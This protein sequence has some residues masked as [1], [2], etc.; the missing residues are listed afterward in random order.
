[1][2]GPIRVLL[3][4]DCR[5][6]ADVLKVVLLCRERVVLVGVAHDLAQASAFLAARAADLVL[7]HAGG[8]AGS[9]AD[10]VRAL[11]ARH[12]ESEVVALGLEESEEAILQVIEAGA[13][14]YALKSASL[15]EVLATVE[16]VH[17]GRTVCSPRVMGAVFDR[18]RRL[19]WDRPTPP[20]GRPERLSAREE[21]VLGMLAAGLSNKEIAHRLG[22][23]LCT[24]KNHVHNILDKLHVRDRRAAVRSTFPGHRPA[25]PGSIP[26]STKRFFGY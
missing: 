26:P 8:G 4:D 21:E 16:S 25:P 17:E 23:T 6:L 15:E 12:P 5:L 3:V 10:R 18:V 2:A 22:I 13:G 9:A 1:M 14:G 7:V 20:A 11:K 19:A 24:V